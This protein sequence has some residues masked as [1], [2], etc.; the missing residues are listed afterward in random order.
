VLALSLFC[1]HRHVRDIPPQP[2][3]SVRGKPLAGGILWGWGLIVV[4]TVHLMFLPSILPHVLEGFHL[5]EAAAIRM[6]GTIMMIYMATAILGNYLLVGMADRVGLTRLIAMACLA[7]A[8]LQGLLFFSTGL[9]T[10]T[11]IRALQT[12]AI[13]AVIPLVIA[14]FAGGGGGTTL[15]FLNSGRFV[16]NALGPMMATFLLAQF[17]LLTLYLTIAGLTLVLL[18]AFLAAGNRQGG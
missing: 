17:S 9:Y 8:A 16:G 2:R 10:F 3:K 18:C 11:V 6:A 13:A 5:T 4:G 7:A 15:G 12:G 1:C 14:T